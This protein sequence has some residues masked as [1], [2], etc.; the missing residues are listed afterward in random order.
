MEFIAKMNQ[1][2]TD[3]EVLIELVLA[4]F[5]ADGEIWTEA[6]KLRIGDA[7]DCNADSNESDL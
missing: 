3:A 1:H 2:F 5:K 7:S 6:Y 4:W